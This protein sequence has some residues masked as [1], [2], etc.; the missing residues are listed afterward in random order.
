MSDTINDMLNNKDE[1]TDK[2]KIIRNKYVANYGK[3]GEVAGKYIINRLIQKQK[4][5]KK[6][7]SN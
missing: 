1:Y 2:I 4:E 3:S 6:N 7:E 5:Q